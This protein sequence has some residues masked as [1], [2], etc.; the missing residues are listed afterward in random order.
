M[1]RQP[2]DNRLQT[3]ETLL[4]PRVG[5]PLAKKCVIDATNA[6]Q[7]LYDGISSTS[8]NHARSV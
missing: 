3:L 4:T 6:N 7:K 1:L 5:D 2:Q 8:I